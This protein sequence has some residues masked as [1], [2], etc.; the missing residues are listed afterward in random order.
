MTFPL[1]GISAIK[2]T[3]LLYNLRVFETM[4]RPELHIAN[5]RQLCIIEL[6]KH[7]TNLTPSTYSNFIYTITTYCNDEGSVKDAVLKYLKSQ[8]CEDCEDSYIYIYNMYEQ[9]PTALNCIELI[10]RYSK[11]NLDLIQCVARINRCDKCCVEII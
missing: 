7:S 6:A 5:L 4:A 9:F 8:V 1:K 2:Y 10:T 3:L 11:N